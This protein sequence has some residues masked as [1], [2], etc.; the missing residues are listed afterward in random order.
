MACVRVLFKIKD[1]N[2]K[3]SKTK[4]TSKAVDFVM[5][6]EVEN[7][8]FVVIIIFSVTIL[9]STVNTC[10][11]FLIIS[12]NH[13]SFRLFKI[14]VLK[15]YLILI[16]WFIDFSIQKVL[17]DIYVSWDVCFSEELPVYYKLHK[18]CFSSCDFYLWI[19]SSIDYT[20]RYY[21]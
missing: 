15:L 6:W 10:P 5:W 7:F 1:W 16:G 18:Y 12:L 4:L 3:Q 11:D 17:Y 8:S 19:V 21:F 14:H 13:L 9:R 2:E 20:Y